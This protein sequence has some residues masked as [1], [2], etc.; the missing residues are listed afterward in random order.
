MIEN[1]IN[2]KGVFFCHL[3]LQEQVYILEEM[4]CTETAWNTLFSCLLHNVI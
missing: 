3:K 4:K 2:Q 1:N